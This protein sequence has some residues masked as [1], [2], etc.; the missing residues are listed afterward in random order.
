MTVELT[1]QFRGGDVLTR[2][3]RSFLITITFPKNFVLEFSSE[4]TAIENLFDFVVGLAVD[5]LRKGRR[6]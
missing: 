4:D 1:N 2:F 6:G 5:D 3:P